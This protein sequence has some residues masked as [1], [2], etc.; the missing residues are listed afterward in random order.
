MEPE[1]SG[2]SLSEKDLRYPKG[3][4][5][6]IDITFLGPVFWKELVYGH[7]MH[8]LVQV[9]FMDVVYIVIDYV[10]DRSCETFKNIKILGESKASDFE[11]FGEKLELVFKFCGHNTIDLQRLVE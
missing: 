1:G 7:P 10:L 2:Y 9:Q 6:L 3:Q 4:I 11:G 8:C 5:L